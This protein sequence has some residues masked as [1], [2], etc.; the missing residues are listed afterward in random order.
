MDPNSAKRRKW[1]QVIHFNL[2]FE[3]LLIRTKAEGFLEGCETSITELFCES[4]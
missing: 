2:Q 1:Y 4:S 3:M